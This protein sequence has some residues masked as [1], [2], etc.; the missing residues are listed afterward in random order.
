MIDDLTF[1]ET[2]GGYFDEIEAA[3][4][5]CSDRLEAIEK[6]IDDYLEGRLDIGGQ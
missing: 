6:A 1:C 5:D 4:H 3:Y 2:C